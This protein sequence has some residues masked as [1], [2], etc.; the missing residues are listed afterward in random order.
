MTF[1]LGGKKLVFGLRDFA[2]ITGLNCG[3]VPRVNKPKTNRGELMARYWWSKASLI[4]DEFNTKFTIRGEKWLSEYK[5]WAANMYILLNVVLGKQIMT[6]IDLSHMAMVNDEE[7]FHSFLWGILSY[8]M[9]IDSVK[10]SI[11]NPKSKIFG[12]DGFLHA[13]LL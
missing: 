11:S 5:V 4:R 8:R 1:N 12:L 3:L 6:Q 2:A 13:I 9:T 10:K 7:K